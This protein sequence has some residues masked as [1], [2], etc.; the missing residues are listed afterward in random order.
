[1][2]FSSLSFIF[3][4]LPI[5][6][7][8]YYIVPMKYKNAILLIGSICFYTFLDINN[9][10][11]IIVSTSVN[12]LLGVLIYRAKQANRKGKIPFCIGII[13][14]VSILLGFKYFLCQ[15]N[16]ISHLP[17]GI[18]FY[19]FTSLSFLIDTYKERYD[20]DT[21]KSNILTYLWMFPQLISGPIVRYGD[22]SQ[23][24]ED[25][26]L[27]VARFESGLRLFIIGLGYKVIIANPLASLW[28]EIQVIG[29][30]S[31]STTLAW[32]GVITYSLQLYFDFNGYSL[33]A[34]G[35]G[36]MLGFNLPVN[37]AHPYMSRSV[38]EFWHRWHITLGL[39]F[40]DYIYIPLGGNRKGKPRQFLNLFIVWILTGIWHG[41]ELH[42][43]M[44]GFFLFVLI[45]LE[46]LCLQQYLRKFKV[47]SRVY[48]LF[49]IGL[50]WMIFAIGD[51]N[52]L[53][54]FFTR[55]FPVFTKN[56]A[57]TVRSMDFMELLSIYWPYLTAGIFLST[58]VAMHW[59]IKNKK[60]V[61]CTLIL[62]VVFWFCIYLL[63]LGSENTFMYFNF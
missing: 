42:F 39:W 6:L 3:R 33:M 51:F 13:Y 57:I 32:M 49:V 24:L 53:V 10:V 14:N 31:I 46:K 7:V 22:L 25:R 55:L 23:Q 28:N 56:M 35:I 44:W 43:V 8:I 30:S 58:P 48:L 1:M 41:S 61:K 60:N 62:T 9:L 4:F 2:L 34:I 18:S 63:V 5:F 54:L 52:Q 59:Y 40:R 45:A 36:E 26:S 47:I 19:T 20:I 11:L 12:C 15:M 29:F 38:S 37:F 27:T 17:L 50:S 21:N 16:Q